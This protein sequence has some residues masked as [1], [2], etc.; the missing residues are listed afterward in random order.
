[1]K[2]YVLL[3]DIEILGVFKTREGAM[4][5]AKKCELR[6]YALQEEVLRP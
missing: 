1:M 2:V 5:M 6:Y 4:E 3:Q